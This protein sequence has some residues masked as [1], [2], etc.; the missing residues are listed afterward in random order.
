M[1]A[2]SAA[3]DPGRTSTPLRPSSNTSDAPGA[4][5]ATIGRPAAIASSSES[6]RPSVSDGRT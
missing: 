1:P 5:E 4:A 2:A 3:T 6:D